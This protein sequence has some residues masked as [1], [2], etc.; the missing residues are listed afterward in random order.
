[1]LTIT[2]E[3]LELI[4]Q[5]DKAVFLELPKLITSCCF[6][7]QECPSVRR[8]EP[9][10]TRNYERRVIQDVIVFVPE[11]LPEIPLV[12]DV[13]TFFGIKSLIVEGWRYF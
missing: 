8:G 1:M 5:Q 12:I 2:P 7:F 11:R 4:Q 3:A 6:D 10:D 13:R 9:L